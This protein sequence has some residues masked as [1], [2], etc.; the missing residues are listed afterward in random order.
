[1]QGLSGA[2]GRTLKL[3]MRQRVLADGSIVVLGAEPGG[4]VSGEDLM[5][6]C[7]RVRVLAFH[8]LPVSTSAIESSLSQ[9]RLPAAPQ[10][11]LRMG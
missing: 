3:R 2:S 9:V 4:G 11:K 1:M 10:R 7:R 5:N 8:R 6:F